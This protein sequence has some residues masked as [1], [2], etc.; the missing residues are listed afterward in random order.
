MP[1]TKEERE[2]YNAR[3]YQDNRAKLLRHR[4]LRYLH[5]PKYRRDTISRATARQQAAPRRLVRRVKARVGP[6]TIT[7]TVGGERR[8]VP[9][10]GAGD[11]A[12]AVGCSAATVRLWCARGILPR[13][14]YRS[15]RGRRRLFTGEQIALIRA[16]AEECGLLAPVRTRPD[17]EMLTRLAALVRERWARIPAGVGEWR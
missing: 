10:F 14:L 4:R 7:I 13:A 11:L 6:T 12:R 9:A 5:D 1:F 15:R 17:S 3:Y 16:S 2:L 8:R